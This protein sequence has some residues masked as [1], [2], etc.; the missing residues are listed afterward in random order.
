MIIVCGGIKGG[1]GKSTLAVNLSLARHLAG[2]DVLLIDADEQASAADF[3]ELREQLHP[4]RPTPIT[5]K[6]SGEAVRT[7]TLKLA[8]RHDDIII[9]V[10]GRDTTSQRAALTVADLFIIPVVPGAFDAWVLDRVDTLVSEIKTVNPDLPAY[11]FLSMVH[12]NDP[13]AKDVLEYIMEL[14]NLSILLPSFAAPASKALALGSRVAFKRAQA[15]GLSIGE[16][17]SAKE[18]PARQEMAALFHAI[19]RATNTPEK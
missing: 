5:I 10:G 1:E 9:D 7:E 14:D 17:T 8:K 4:D 11:V 12:P 16:T 2:R 13:D 6:L 15:K 3:M 18:E 19:E